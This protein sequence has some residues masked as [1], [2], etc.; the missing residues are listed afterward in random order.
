MGKCAPRH[1]KVCYCSGTT[2]ADGLS[3]ELTVRSEQVIPFV[4][5]ATGL[6]SQRQMFVPRHSVR[7]LLLQTA[8]HTAPG[9]PLWRPYVASK[10]LVLRGMFRAAG[11][12]HAMSLAS[13]DG[14]YCMMVRTEDVLHA[15]G[16]ALGAVAGDKPGAHGVPV[17]AHEYP[18]AEQ[19][20]CDRERDSNREQRARNASP[21]D[22]AAHALEHI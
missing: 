1:I 16:E 12:V 8:A 17:D 22:D 19:N 6:R 7:R 13:L 21:R 11:E 18:A 2:V 3:P 10:S 5:R 14:E 4:G 20:I 9:H 15:S